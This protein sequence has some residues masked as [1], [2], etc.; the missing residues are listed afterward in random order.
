MQ[1]LHRIQANS[2]ANEPKSCFTHKLERFL[3]LLVSFQLKNCQ[4][5]CNFQNTN[6]YDT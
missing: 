3:E 5:S 2:F 1:Q 4:I 6:M